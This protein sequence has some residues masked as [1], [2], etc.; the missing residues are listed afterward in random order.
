M[1]YPVILEDGEDG[2]IVVHCP[3][4]RGCISQ[5]ETR[6]EALVNIREAIALTL[7]VRRELGLPLSDNEMEFIEATEVDIAV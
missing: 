2:W 3:T 4:L 7:E 5:G 6:A 1:K